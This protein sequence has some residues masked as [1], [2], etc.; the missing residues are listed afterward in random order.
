MPQDAGEVSYGALFTKLKEN[1]DATLI[2]VAES[3]LG[4]DLILNAQSGHR[5]DPG[6]IVY[7]LAARRIKPGEIDWPAL[8]AG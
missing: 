3:A 1:H 8:K 7:F 6:S 5:V 2:G 4:D